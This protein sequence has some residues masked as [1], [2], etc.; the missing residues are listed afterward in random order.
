MIEHRLSLAHPHTRTVR[1]EVRADLPP[2]TA[3]QSLVFPV[4]T[5]G[6]YLVR[7]HQR[8][9]HDFSAEADG[10]TAAWEKTDKN[11][12]TVATAGAR[13][14]VVRYEVYA[15][16]LTVRTSHVDDT[17]AFLNPIGLLPFLPGRES[18]PQR[19]VVAD[20]PQGWDVATALESDGA[21]PHA[22][23]ASDYDELVDSPLECGPHARDAELLRF[24][25]L[26][27]PHEIVIWGRSQLDRERFRNDVK[28]IVET[29]AALFGGLPYKRYVH[30]LLIGD[31][32]RGGLEHRASAALLVARSSLAKARGYEDLLGLVSHEH[33][34]AWNVKRIKPEAFTPYELSRENHTRQLWAFEG[35]TSY[36]ED[37]VLVRAGLMSRSRYIEVLSERLTDLARIEGRHRQSV[38]DASFDAWIRLYRADENTANSTVSYYLKGSLVGVL[39]DL[40]IRRRTDG[41]RS[42]DDVMRLLWERYGSRGLGVPEDGVEAICIEVGGEGMTPIIEQAVRGTG[43]VP[44]EEALAGHGLKLEKRV[45]RGSDDKG[46]PAPKSEPHKSD[47]GMSLRPDGSRLKVPFVRRGSPA[48]A[49]GVAP[50]DELVAIDGLRAESGTA[51]AHLQSLEPGTSVE[52][53]LFRRDEL[54]TLT[55]RTA[56]PRLDTITVTEQP[57]AGARERELLEAWLGRA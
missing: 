52:L 31:Q 13:S 21:Q 46:G 32:G 22:Y 27:C 34:H 48:E 55:L 50:G 23:L 41:S 45:A 36:Y 16:E 53:T 33:F 35:L 17:H 49:A 3:A 51:L 5:P 4:W 7:E 40:E 12:Y 9:V 18:E 29:Q 54:R 37:V 14:L 25:A 44:L 24:E 2:G 57:D 11:T 38:A 20:L 42:L 26:G 30:I 15:H 1:I 39:L 6:S 43:D 8:H 19:L 10:R 56:E 28:R 47:V